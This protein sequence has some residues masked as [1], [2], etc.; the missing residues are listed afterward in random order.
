MSFTDLF[1][2][3]STSTRVRTTFAPGGPAAAPATGVFITPQSLTSFPV[4][5][6]IVTGLWALAQRL[7]AWGGSTL[8]VLCLSI[9]IGLLVFL[10]NIS[11]PTAAPKS[12]K[13]WLV[14]VSVA[15]INCLFLCAA[16]LGILGKKY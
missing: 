3:R 1:V 9:A 4:A 8:V 14:A 15:L 6:G 13:A 5:S 12:A 7:F 11:D 16:A 2:V 10:I